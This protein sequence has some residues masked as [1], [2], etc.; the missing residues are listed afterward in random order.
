ML[1]SIMLKYDLNLDFNFT[2]KMKFPRFKFVKLQE[3]Q[4][5]NAAKYLRVLLF[6]NIFICAYYFNKLEKEKII[7][8]DVP[9]PEAAKESEILS[10]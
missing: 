10:S 8:N 1:Q 3:G 2:N 6:G 7:V 4:K 9:D 5:S